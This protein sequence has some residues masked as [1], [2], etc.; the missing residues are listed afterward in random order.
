VRTVGTSWKRDSGLRTNRD[1]YGALITVKAG[2]RTFVRESRTASGLYSA[3]DPRIHFGLG[4]LDTIDSI[5][6]RW[7][8]GAHSLIKRPA[9]DSLQLVTEPMENTK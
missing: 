4:A 5:E 3:N 8:S 1:G 9:L 2:G 6:V 7:P